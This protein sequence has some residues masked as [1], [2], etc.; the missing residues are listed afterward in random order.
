[1]TDPPGRPGA[2]LPLRSFLR[3]VWTQG[4]SAFRG[5]PLRIERPTPRDRELVGE[6]LRAGRAGYVRY[7]E[8]TPLGEPV[9]ELTPIGARWLGLGAIFEEGYG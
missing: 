6:I 9:F 5:P 1:M 2:R 8:T 3:A 7:I 4:G